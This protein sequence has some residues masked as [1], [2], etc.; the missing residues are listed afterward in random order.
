M[1]DIYNYFADHLP[2]DSIESIRPYLNKQLLDKDDFFIREG[3]YCQKI[4]FVEKGSFVFYNYMN[5]EKKVCGLA[6]EGSW[7]THYESLTQKSPAT[8]FIQALE[9]SQV[10]Y[11]EVSDLEHCEDELPELKEFRLQLVGTYYSQTIRRASSLANFGAEERYLNLLKEQPELFQRVP[12][13]LIASYLGIKP[14]SLS[15]IRKAYQQKNISQ[16]ITS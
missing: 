11:F 8:E 5:G 10:H 1:I 7:I 12:L 4:G 6:L 16:K 15:R 13:Y 3:Q 9:P 2:Q 14:Q